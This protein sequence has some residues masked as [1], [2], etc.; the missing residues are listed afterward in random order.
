MVRNTETV[1]KRS[2]T[3]AIHLTEEVTVL[4]LTEI[5]VKFYHTVTKPFHILRQQLISIGDAVIQ[6]SHFVVCVSPKHKDIEVW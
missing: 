3:E 5:G 4:Y 2:L 6:V 1:C